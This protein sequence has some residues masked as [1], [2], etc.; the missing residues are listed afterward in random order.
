MQIDNRIRDT[1]KDIIDVVNDITETKYDKNIEISCNIEHVIR[2][3][4][5]VIYWQ[6]LN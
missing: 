4:D 3:I 1:T 2:S 5:T 6:N